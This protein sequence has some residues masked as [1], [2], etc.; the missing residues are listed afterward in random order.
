[1]K[2][3]LTPLEQLQ[4]Q[5]AGGWPGLIGGFIAFAVKWFL[6]GLLLKMGWSFL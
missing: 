6:I 5:L 1:M 2:L 3:N 4:F